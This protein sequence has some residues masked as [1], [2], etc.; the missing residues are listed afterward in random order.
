MTAEQ[1]KQAQEKAASAEKYNANVKIV[2]DKMNAAKAA[3]QP[4][5]PD[6]DKAIAPDGRSGDSRAQ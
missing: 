6:Y 4:P 2:N 5:T 3:V 1:A